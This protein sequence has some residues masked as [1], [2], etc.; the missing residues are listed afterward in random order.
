MYARL[1]KE[2]GMLL[3]EDNKKRT[4]AAPWLDEERKILQ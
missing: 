3:P 2:H 4:D 1:E